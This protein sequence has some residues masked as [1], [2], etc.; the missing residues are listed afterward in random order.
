MEYNKV[1]SVE[2]RKLLYTVQLN[3]TLYKIAEKFN[4]TV[5][6]IMDANIICKP[7]L[8]SVGMPLII[9]D[10]QIELP[11]AGLSPYYIVLPGDTID[12]ISKYTGIPVQ[13]LAEI[14]QI[15]NP[16]IL[17]TG[18]ELLLVPPS[19]QSP[20]ELKR[21]WEEIPDDDC[22]VYGPQEQGILYS[23]SFGW[24]GFGEEAIN[25]LLQLLENPCEV[26]RQYAVI[27]LGRLA[28]NGRVRNALIP[29]L[30]DDSLSHLVRIAL[31]RIELRSRGLERVHINMTDNIIASMPDSNSS[32][33]ELPIG[34]EIVILR[35]FIP[36]PTGEE[37]PR[38]GIQIYDYVQ[39]VNTNQRGFVPRFGDAAITFI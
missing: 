20:E 30:K 25:P 19:S 34:A 36:S 27:S 23:G 2:E 33:V 4:T 26:I 38:G 22:M 5:Q 24:S 15:N 39:L 35:W 8:I 10:K 7:S 32:F 28:L 16:D 37:G 6:D 11:K 29:L 21:E 17:Y 9:P 14:N 31:R 12:C 1:K 13:T 18:R 3:D